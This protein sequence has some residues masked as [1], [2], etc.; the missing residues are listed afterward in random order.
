MRHVR[1]A[2]EFR[3]ELAGHVV[4]MVFQFDDFHQLAVRRGA[5]EHETL[6]LIALAIR[7]VELVAVAVTFHDDVGLVECVGFG[8]GDEMA[9]L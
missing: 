5:A 8:A 7:V 4:G 9:G 6:F 3:M 2:L 1:L